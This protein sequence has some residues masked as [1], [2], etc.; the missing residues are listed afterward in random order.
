[1]TNSTRILIALPLLAFGCGATNTTPDGGTIPKAPALGAQM[2]RMGRPTINVAVTDPFDLDGKRDT[3]GGVR[4]T[5]NADADPSKWV[6]NWQP[7]IAA[8]LAVYDGADGTCGNQLGAAAAAG[9]VVPKDR[10]AVLAGAL[11]DDRLWVDTTQTTCSLY[12]A[13][14]AN[15]LLS[16]G[17]KDCG[18]RTPLE[19]VVDETYTAAAV[20]PTGFMANGT[21]AVTDGVPSDADSTASL[22]VFPFLGDAK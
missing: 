10:Y 4:D 5:Y 12:L 17:A 16:L 11:A 18:G 7:S 2:D 22:S 13:M 1:M 8:T 20:G 3:A 21:F 14:E 6:A 19:D 15:A 9:G